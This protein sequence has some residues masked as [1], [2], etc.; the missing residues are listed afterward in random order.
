MVILALSNK[1]LHIT[2]R[3]LVEFLDI[4]DLDNKHYFK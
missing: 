2:K 3:F 1:A 4:V